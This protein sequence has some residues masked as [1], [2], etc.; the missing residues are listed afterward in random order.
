[1][2]DVP[3]GASLFNIAHRVTCARAH[4][5][6]SA[7]C[8]RVLGDQRA[9]RRERDS[10]RTCMLERHTWHVVW[11]DNLPRLRLFKRRPRLRRV[12]RTAEGRG[13]TTIPPSTPQP[14]KPLPVL[15]IATRPSEA[16]S[17]VVPTDVLASLLRSPMLSL[18]LMRAQERRRHRCQPN[19]HK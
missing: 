2:L 18:R 17:L 14:L 4:V 1:M 5:Q 7:Q 11:W 19:T 6:M 10:S 13:A 16:L 8:V 3:G 12:R 9:S 15:L